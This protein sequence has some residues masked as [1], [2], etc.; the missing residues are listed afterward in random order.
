MIHAGSSRAKGTCPQQPANPPKQHPHVPL[1][2]KGLRWDEA[3][4]SQQSPSLLHCEVKSSVANRA[5]S[6]RPL[7]DAPQMSGVSICS[8]RP[9]LPG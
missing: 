5:G 7:I 1:Q 9:V 3:S 4:S 6:L 8:R 2:Q